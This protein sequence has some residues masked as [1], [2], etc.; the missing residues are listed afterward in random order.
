MPT[1]S[2]SDWP[3][4]GYLSRQE[5]EEEISNLKENGNILQVDF[6]MYIDI[7]TFFCMRN[8]YQHLVLL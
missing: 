3:T 7:L 2:F 1:T 5:A 6:A 4:Q 8:V